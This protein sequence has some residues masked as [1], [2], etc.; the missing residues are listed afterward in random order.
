MS[1]SKLIQKHFRKMA[2]GVGLGIAGAAQYFPKLGKINLNIINIFVLKN[3]R[4]EK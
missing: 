4:K 3:I 2:V 1:V